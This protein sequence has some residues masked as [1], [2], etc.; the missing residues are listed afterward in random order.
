M[1]TTTEDL[2]SFYFHDPLNND[3]TYKSYIHICNVSDLSEFK[4][5]LDYMSINL[6]KGMFFLFRDGIFPC[7]DDPGNINGGSFCLKVIKSDVNT[8]WTDLVTK[9]LSETILLDGASGGIQDAI[10]GLSISPKNKF[11]I[12]KVW[13]NNNTVTKAMLN[14]DF[15][16]EYKGEVLYKSHRQQ[17]IMDGM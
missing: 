12:I 4:A 17:I 9:L 8:F 2:W 15:D 13:T 1:D 16:K 11:C 5:V 6:Q 14:I 10:T 3:W 7:W